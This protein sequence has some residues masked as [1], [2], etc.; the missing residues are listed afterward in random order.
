MGKRQRIPDVCRTARRAGDQDEAIPCESSDARS[1][2]VCFELADRGYGLCVRVEV[3]ARRIGIPG[4]EADATEVVA[5][6]DEARLGL[7]EILILDLVVRPEKGNDDGGGTKERVTECRCL[8]V[9]CARIDPDAIEVWIVLICY[10]N[11]GQ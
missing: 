7:T 2:L 6:E 11:G 3:A 4:V 10:Q 5:D 8:D 9:P 1:V